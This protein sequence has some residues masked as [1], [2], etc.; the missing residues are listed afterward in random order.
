MDS[1]YTDYYQQQ[2]QQQPSVCRPHCQS[3]INVNM[4]TDFA[5]GSFQ[6]DHP[7]VYQQEQLQPTNYYDPQHHMNHHHYYFQQQ[8]PQQV[9]NQQPFFDSFVPSTSTPPNYFQQEFQSYPMM[10]QPPYYS[11]NENENNN[12]MMYVPLS[13]LQTIQSNLSSPNLM[14]DQS[15]STM[16]VISSSPMDMHGSSSSMPVTDS[17]FN[18]M[19][20]SLHHHHHSLIGPLSPP[21][22][23]SHSS[24][25]KNEK[26]KSKSRKSMKQE[27][28]ETTFQ[29]RNDQDHQGATSFHQLSSSS[30]MKKESFSSSSSLSSSSSSSSSSTMNGLFICDFENCGKEFGRKYNLNS[31]KL[32]HSKEKPHKCDYNNCVKRFARL[33]DLRR[34]YLIH[35]NVKPHVCKY[36]GDDFSR[37]DA[38]TRH[39]KKKEVCDY[40]LRHDFTN[41]INIRRLKKVK[42][43]GYGEKK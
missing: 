42:P 34:H 33:H 27:I 19:D 16:S 25:K 20:S 40:K 9:V 36:C 41:P 43:T 37:S 24:N 5:L 11:L 2:Q 23:P 10:E 15:C 1:Y 35:T 29:L 13:P 39:Y 38:L 6:P 18:L 30:K 8:Q 31:H 26:G 21:Y 32:S 17:Y 14:D 4:N 28:I 3:M 12:K 22:S 7:M